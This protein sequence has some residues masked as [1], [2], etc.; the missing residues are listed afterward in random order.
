MV[1]R[2][3]SAAQDDRG[4]T[5]LELVVVVALL[6]MVLLIFTG[7]LASVQR[8]YQTQASR[9]QSNDQA[10]LAVEE[11][12]REIRSG[13]VFYDPNNETCTGQPVTLHC[14]GISP[15]MALRI[16]SQT[17][18]STRNPGNRCIQ[19]RIMNRQLQ[20]RDWAITWRDNPTTL[21]D[22]WRVVAESIMNQAV[23]PQV[24]AFMLDNS[25]DT[26]GGRI[27]K[28][29]ILANANSGKGRT[30]Q[31]GVSITGRDTEFGYPNNICDDIPPY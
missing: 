1:R 15:G 12:D 16:Y 2:M 10:R 18:G 17:N 7:L 21:V 27:I 3:G 23:S 11:L 19:W 26:F 25:Q 22:P 31:I 13:N 4:T 24:A 30:V 14:I 5:L 8:S 6:S 28:I 9:S 29:L 20:R